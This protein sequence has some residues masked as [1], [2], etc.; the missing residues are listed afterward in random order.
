M[1]LFLPFPPLLPPPPR[2]HAELPG[3]GS[4]LSCR[5]PLGYRGRNAGPFTH[6]AGPG[7]EPASQ[8]LLLGHSGSAS[9]CLF[10][11]RCLCEAAGGPARWVSEPWVRGPHCG[12]PLPVSAACPGGPLG[13]TPRSGRARPPSSLSLS[14][15]QAAWEFWLPGC[16]VFAFRRHCPS[17]FPA[18]LCWLTPWS[19]DSG[20]PPGVTLATGGV[21]AQR[22]PSAVRMLLGGGAKHP[23]PSCLSS[24][25]LALWPPPPLTFAPAQRLTV[26]PRAVWLMH[27]SA[28]AALP[29]LEPCPVTQWLCLFCKMVGSGLG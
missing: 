14:W 29:G 24:G 10:G 25:R 26:W 3:W 23:V 4:D 21:H 22:P 20:C 9:S 6:G 15:A 7:I 1:M 27:R 13:W 16:C 5:G 18:R 8:L 17:C 28:G 12:R 2:R 19:A 11:L